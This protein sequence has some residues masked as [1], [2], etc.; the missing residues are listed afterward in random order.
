MTFDFLPRLESVRRAMAAKGVD[1]L[2]LPPGADLLYFCGYDA[3][4]SERPTSLVIRPR[5]PA[6][7]LVP[8]L[9]GSRVPPASPVSLEVWAESEDPLL[10][11]AELLPRTGTVALGDQT[12][13]S[14]LLKLQEKLPASRFVPGSPLT[15]PLRMRKDEKELAELRRASRAA[16]RVAIRL[17]GLSLE[18]ATELDWARRIAAHLVE[19]GCDRAEFAI[20]AGGE[21]SASPHHEPTARRM[22]RGDMLVTDFGGRLGG[23]FSDTTRTFYLGD[24][25]PEEHRRVHAAVLNAQTAARNLIRPGITAHAVDRAAREVIAAAGYGSRFIHRTGHGIGLEVHEPPYIAEGNAQVLEP[26]MTFSL[27]P[28]IYLPGRFGVR[29]EDLVVVTDE[30]AESLNR[31]PRDLALSN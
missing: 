4:P 8:E 16:D 23:Y 14:L 13:A 29:I 5:G 31:S 21:N 27:E 24:E 11:I 7:L 1:A 6:T 2:L 26:G 25:P 3:T 22:C 12:W 30:G 18:G 9:E 20:V 17:R 28:G 15:A 19:E 10:R